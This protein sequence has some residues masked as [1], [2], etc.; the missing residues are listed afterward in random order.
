MAC[1]NLPPSIR[2][3]PENM[4]LA[5]IVPGPEEPKL[6]MLNHYQDPLITN[7]LQS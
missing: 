2:Y 5:G 6:E 1:L 7:M 4:Y 3:K